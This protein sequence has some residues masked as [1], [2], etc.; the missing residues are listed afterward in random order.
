MRKTLLSSFVT[1][2]PGLAAGT[3]LAAQLV[4]PASAA[5]ASPAPAP[6]P[7][8]LAHVP[9]QDDEAEVSPPVITPAAAELRAA[10]GHARSFSDARQ[11]KVF[12]AIRAFYEEHRFEPAFLRDGKPTRQASAL[13]ERL[14]EAAADGLD[15][16]DYADAKLP[17]ARLDDLAERARAELAIAEAAARFLVD[18]AAGRIAPNSVAPRDI[19]LKPE[20]PDIAAALDELGTTDDVVA[21]LAGYEPPHRQYAVLKRHLAELR[22]AN[23]GEPLPRIEPGKVLKKGVRDA[24]VPVLRQRLGMEAPDMRN[25][26]LR[27]Y[28]DHADLEIFDEDVTAAVE[29]FQTANGL[30]VDGMVGPQTLAAL[31]GARREERIAAI[32]VNMERWRWAPRQLGRYYVFVNVPEFMVRVHRD[33]KTTFETRVVVGKPANRT[34]VFSDEM[35][36]IV[37]NPYWNV[38]NSIVS[39]EML[40][41]IQRDPYGYFAKNG[42]QLLADIRGKTYYLDPTRIDWYA[43]DTKLL[44]VRQPPGD[45]NALGRI[46]FMFPNRHAVYLHDT[47]AKSLFQ[48]TSRAYSHGCVRVQD[49]LAFADAVLAEDGEWNSD[50]LKRMFGG[51]ETQVNMSKRLPVHLAYFTLVPQKDG[52]LLTVPDLY[53]YDARMRQM[54]NL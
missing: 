52:S 10:L 2:V 40:P 47:P 34:P 16:S 33:G 13:V 24:R 42:Y 14:G 37:V 21:T 46:K 38:P 50:R 35:D 6:A 39:K 44:R 25:P 18:L 4:G 32:V 26:E 23:D 29:A 45:R 19:F 36:H 30:T 49:P 41:Q 15:P 11:K 1:A 3:L 12:A 51:Q 31:N 53:G 8:Q 20:L 48:R 7:I 54:L 9:P 27:P 43:I 28:L 5:P 22:A 17:A